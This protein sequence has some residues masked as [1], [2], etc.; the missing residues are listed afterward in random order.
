MTLN[1]GGHTQT[2]NATNEVFMY[3]E[4]ATVTINTL[5]CQGC[6]NPTDY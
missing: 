6:G 1:L 4:D 5:N 3:H 2:Q